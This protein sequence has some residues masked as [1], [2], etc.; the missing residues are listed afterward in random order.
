[1]IAYN[2]LSFAAAALSLALA[3]LIF[4]RRPREWMAWVVSLTLL[5]YGI[6]MAGPL[7]MLLGQTA[8]GQSAAYAGQMV[9][10][11]FFIILFFLFPDGE[12]VPGWTRWL[13]LLVAPWTLVL[14]G[15]QLI[16]FVESNLG[17]YFVLY[18][19]PSLAAPLAQLIRYRRVSDA[20]QRQQTQWVA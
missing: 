14:A 1:D 10:W 19:V 9:L 17:L 7:E 6:V 2:L 3:A 4:W 15:L 13:T 16:P 8:A 11:G 20:V 5:V 18:S 12:F